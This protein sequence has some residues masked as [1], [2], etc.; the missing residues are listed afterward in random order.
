MVCEMLSEAQEGVLA[1]SFHKEPSREDIER[2]A[3]QIYGT[4]SPTGQ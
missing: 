3:F 2:R 4:R 1:V